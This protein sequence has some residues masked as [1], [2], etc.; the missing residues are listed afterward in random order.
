VEV[1]GVQV[2]YE[3]DIEQGNMKAEYDDED[4]DKEK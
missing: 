3:K 4:N 2:Q 1:E